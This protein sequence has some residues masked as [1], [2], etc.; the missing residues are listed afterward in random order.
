[1]S[2]APLSVV[3]AGMDRVHKRALTIRITFVPKSAFGRA[4]PK[5][6]TVIT[7]PWRKFVHKPALTKI[8]PNLVRQCRYQSDD[9]VY[10]LVI[11]IP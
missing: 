7:L 2:R 4:V 8:R 5:R 6:D 11:L 1:M 9:M 3:G 10:R